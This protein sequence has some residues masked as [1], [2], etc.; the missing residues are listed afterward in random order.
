MF[1]LLASSLGF[2]GSGILANAQLET[3]DPGRRLLVKPQT[4]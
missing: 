2:R 4:L 3:G 1:Q